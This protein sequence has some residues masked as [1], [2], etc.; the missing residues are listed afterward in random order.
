ML[1][2]KERLNLIK[3]NTINAFDDIFG[4]LYI[5]RKLRGGVW[6]K[7]KDSTFFKDEVISYFEWTRNHY[8]VPFRFL[9]FFCRE[10][11]KKED[12]SKNEST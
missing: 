10:I 3:Q 11:I 1:I 2:S 7:Y 9:N 4:I 6:T 12:H 8:V 5:Y